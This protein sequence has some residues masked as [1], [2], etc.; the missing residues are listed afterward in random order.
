[1]GKYNECMFL[2]LNG[3]ITS[4]QFFLCLHHAYK[5]YRWIICV[6]KNVHR[7]ERH[8]NKKYILLHQDKEMLVKFSCYPC[9]RL[10]KASI[11]FQNTF[12][13][14]DNHRTQNPLMYKA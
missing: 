6:H 10:C 7:Y 8:V 1:M 5:F 14:S 9:C 4:P 13:P 11:N 2:S 12:L 3:L